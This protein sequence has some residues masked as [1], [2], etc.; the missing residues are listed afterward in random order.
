MEKY[1]AHEIKGGIFCRTIPVTVS[2][3]LGGMPYAQAGWIDTV[4]KDGTTASDFYS[5]SSK[6][7]TAFRAVVDGRQ[8]VEGISTQGSSATSNYSRTT[9]RQC[10]AALRELG[11]CDEEV[12]GIKRYLDRGGKFALLYHYANGGKQWV[13]AFTGEVIA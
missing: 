5:Y 8:V 1:I 4:Q 2:R 12:R 7:F 9:S 6:I 13:D 10:T 11:L 3:R